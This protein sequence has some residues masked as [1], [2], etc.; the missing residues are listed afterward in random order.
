MSAALTAQ[1]ARITHTST[2]L[3]LT[4]IFTN[5]LV[6]GDDALMATND[7]GC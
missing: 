3:A 6:T 1:L 2:R 4:E 5:L 7:R